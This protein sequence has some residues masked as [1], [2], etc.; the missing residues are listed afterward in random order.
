MPKKTS[1]CTYLRAARS[2]LEGM[3]SD[4]ANAF[5]A[6]VAREINAEMARQGI[7]SIRSFAK[8]VGTNHTSWTNK[9]SPHL[10]KFVPMTVSDLARCAQALHVEPADLIRRAEIAANWQAIRD[11]ED[12]SAD[13]DDLE[14]AADRV[15]RAATSG[16]REK[17]RKSAA[18]RQKRTGSA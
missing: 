6:A 9:L 8:L 10:E 12:R 14:V 2:I 5:A 4:Y 11:L 16:V 7:R 13:R 17:P 15:V 18:D 3:N 1:I